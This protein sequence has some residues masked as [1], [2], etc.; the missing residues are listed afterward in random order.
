[1]RKFKVTFLSSVPFGETPLCFVLI[2]VLTFVFCLLF[3]VPAYAGLAVSV[4]GGD[5]A[6]GDIGMGLVKETTGNTW[7]ATNQGDVLEHVY[8][9]VDGT[10]WHPAAAADD[11]VFVLKHDA[12]GSWS[13]PITN[14]GDGIALAGLIA[15]GTSTF[16]L[17]FTGPTAS[18]GV[19]GEQTLT[20]TL[21]AKAYTLADGVW[22]TID[23]ELVCVGTATGYLMWPRYQ[24]CTGTNDGA[25]KQWKTANTDGEPVWNDTT[26]TYSYGAETSADYPA[27]AWVEGVDYKGYTDWRLPTKDELKELYDD[28]LTHIAYSSSDY[29]SCTKCGSTLAYFVRFSIGD[30]YGTNKTGSYYVRAVRAGQ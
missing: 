15:G 29:W 19:S 25:T 30:V 5:W 17:Q 14:T 11:K 18:T 22:E 21:T 26:K 6:V 23:D 24:V 4:S 8:I 7:T 9:K 13:D 12:T 16:D 28:G 10:N 20:V 27:F 2:C 3:S 1:M